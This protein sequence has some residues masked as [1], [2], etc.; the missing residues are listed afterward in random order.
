[1]DVHSGGSAVVV[2]VRV[3][4]ADLELDVGD[5]LELEL[6]VVLGMLKVVLVAAPVRL[7][8]GPKQKSALIEQT[9]YMSP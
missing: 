2:L 4:D 7:D 1:M 5:E 3:V 9:V 8:V 6:E